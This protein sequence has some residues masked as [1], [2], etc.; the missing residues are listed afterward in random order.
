MAAKPHLERTKPTAPAH[1]RPETQAW[2]IEVVTTWELDA[3]HVRLLTLA[4]ESWDRTVAAREILEREGLTVADRHGVPKVHPAVAVERD[5]R[6]AFRQ[7][8]R[9]LDLDCAAPPE[10]ARPPALRRMR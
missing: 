2:F 5:S 3:H 6:A 9:E 8:V 4:C 7:C 10:P 1:L